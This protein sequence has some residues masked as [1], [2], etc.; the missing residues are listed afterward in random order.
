MLCRKFHLYL[1]SI[2]Y[3]IYIVTKIYLHLLFGKAALEIANN[4]LMQLELGLCGFY[5]RFFACQIVY[6][7][8]YE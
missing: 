8:M 3:K 5:V 7:K 1:I 2:N 6:K 4:L